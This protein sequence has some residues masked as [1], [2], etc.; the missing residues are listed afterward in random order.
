MC[1]DIFAEILKNINHVSSSCVRDVNFGFLIILGKVKYA[2]VGPF[3]IVKEM[4]DTCMV[5]DTL[6][7]MYFVDLF[8]LYQVFLFGKYSNECVC[9]ISHKTC[10]WQSWVR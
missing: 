7:I 3:Q 9:A 1:S 4:A 10:A 8:D 5:E 2:L 6:D